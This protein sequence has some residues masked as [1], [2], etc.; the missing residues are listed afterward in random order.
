MLEMRE[1]KK[2]KRN[3]INTYFYFPQHFDISLK[4]QLHYWDDL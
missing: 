4:Q 2:F 3:K 1:G